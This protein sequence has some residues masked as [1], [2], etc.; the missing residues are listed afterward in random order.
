MI[1]VTRIDLIVSGWKYAYEPLAPRG[2]AE[3]LIHSVGE[4]G[5][6]DRR[7]SRQEDSRMQVMVQEESPAMRADPSPGAVQAAV[8]G[9]LPTIRVSVF[10]A[11]I[12][13]L[14]LFDLVMPL[15][16]GGPSNSSHTVVSF[17]YTF[18]ITRMDIGFGSAVAV[19]L[20]IV[21]VLF[22]V[23]YKTTLMR[24]EKGATR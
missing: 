2:L 16:G 4:L 7:T 8:R 11:I 12:G 21:C 18:G 9:L 3:C 6:I 13:S 5:T 24:P 17:L 14:Q 22:T 15:T 10:F 19:V 23:C 20:F 1:P